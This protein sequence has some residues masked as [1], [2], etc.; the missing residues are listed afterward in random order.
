[1][2]NASP[3]KKKHRSQCF[4]W[5]LSFRK[6]EQYSKLRS[7]DKFFCLIK[8][9]DSLDT[10]EVFEVIWKVT[11]KE[12][13]YLTE[14]RKL[15]GL[16]I[17]H[18]EPTT[19]FSHKKVKLNKEIIYEE[20]ETQTDFKE[21]KENTMIQVQPEA[22]CDIPQVTVTKVI[23]ETLAHLP[24]KNP[25]LSAK[26]EVLIKK[27]ISQNDRATIDAWHMVRKEVKIEMI[28]RYPFLFTEYGFTI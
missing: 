17:V 25:D 15:I 11:F 2:K 5:T 14:V 8:K 16:I 21:E 13:Y 18:V 28:N 27:S 3:K 10:N 6:E 9:E 22:V 12:K 7:N 4:N 26:T 1:M 24:I 19:T 23:K 20:K